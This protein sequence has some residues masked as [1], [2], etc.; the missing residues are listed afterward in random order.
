MPTYKTQTRKMLL[1]YLQ[2]HA[3]ETLSA[4]IISKALPEISVSAVYR[5][6]AALEKEGLLAAVREAGGRERYYR[7]TA[8]EQCRRHLHLSCKK[9]GRTFHLGE[10]QT[11]ALVESIAALDNFAVDRSSTVLYGICEN[12]RCTRNK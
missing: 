7:F 12:C 5:N 1:D 9:C 10:A 6:L 4:S 8:A 11:E 2:S 3:D